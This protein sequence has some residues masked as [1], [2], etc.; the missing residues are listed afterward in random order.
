MSLGSLCSQSVCL[1]SDFLVDVNLRAAQQCPLT[2]L[3]SPSLLAEAVQWSFVLSLA[4]EI[5][6]LNRQCILRCWLSVL[7][8]LLMWKVYTFGTL[9]LR[10]VSS[11]SP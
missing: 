2:V 7:R 1:L 8:L 5:P 6:P 4:A 3:V 11:V 10:L 9:T